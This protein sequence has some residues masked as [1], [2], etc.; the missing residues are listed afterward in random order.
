MT[1]LNILLI[2]FIAV[3][4]IDISGVVDHITAAI[5]GWL[6]KGAVKKPF[7]L[8]PFTCSLCMTF[9]TSIIYVICIGEWSAII[10]AYICLIAFLTPRIADLMRVVDALLAKLFS[11]LIELCS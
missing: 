3:F 11:N 1:Y 6:T 5:A 9:W 4:I 7:Q 10:T 2:A 8:K